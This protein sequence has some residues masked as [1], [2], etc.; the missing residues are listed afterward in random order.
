MKK[1]AAI[2]IGFKI[3]GRTPLKN[4]I[5]NIKYVHQTGTKNVECA[6]DKGFSGRSVCQK[7]LR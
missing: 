4:M 6:F 5:M 1:P 2:L 7:Y 3:N